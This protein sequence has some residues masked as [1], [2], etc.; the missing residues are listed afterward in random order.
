MSVVASQ[1]TSVSIVCSTVGS[2]AGQRKHQSSASLAFVWGIHRWPVNSPH[3]RL[4][5]RKMFPFDDGGGGGGGFSKVV[6]TFNHVGGSF[7]LSMATSG[8]V[9]IIP[10]LCVVCWAHFMCHHEL[11][12]TSVRHPFYFLNSSWCLTGGKHY[13]KI[14]I[15]IFKIVLQKFTIPGYFPYILFFSC[16]FSLLSS[17]R[18]VIAVCGSISVQGTSWGLVSL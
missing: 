6:A 17:C 1:I 18:F 9:W 15:A 14:T 13:Q 10:G 2:G 5:T 8:A 7:N 11:W 4:V 12:P 3:K 16:Y